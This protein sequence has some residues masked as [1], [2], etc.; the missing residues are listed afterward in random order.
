MTVTSLTR[1]GAVATDPPAPAPRDIPAVDNDP[2]TLV[3]NVQIA[4]PSGTPAADRVIALA[5]RLQALAADDVTSARVSTT[6]SVV[7]DS[8]ETEV[9]GNPTPMP[10][11]VSPAPAPR[12]VSSI[13]DEDQALA[14]A[15]ASVEPFVGAGLSSV[16]EA[17]LVLYP[18]RRVALLDGE[19]L[20]F[21]RREYDLLLYLIENGGRVLNRMQLLSQVWGYPYLG[22]ERTVDVH[23]RRLRAKLG[24]RGPQLHTVRGVGYRLD[25][26]ERAAVVRE[27]ALTA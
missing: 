4:V 6:I 1:P 18:E 27:G 11:P 17:D 20:E 23:V 7:L 25:R 22:G 8:V 15:L 14:V 13:L 2:A 21:T 12:P 9:R 3:V 24:G 10:V 5:R 19:P 26:L 16:D